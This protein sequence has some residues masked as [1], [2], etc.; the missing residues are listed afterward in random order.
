MHGSRQPPVAVPRRHLSIAS[1]DSDYEKPS[2]QSHAPSAIKSV[3]TEPM[4]VNRKVADDEEDDVKDYEDVVEC[5]VTLD[6]RFE[7]HDYVNVV[8][9]DHLTKFLNSSLKSLQSTSAA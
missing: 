6:D 3:V 7:R 9:K 8:R 5:R 1:D 2:L 4:Y